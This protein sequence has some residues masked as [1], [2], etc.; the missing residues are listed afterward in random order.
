MASK[1]SYKNEINAVD[2]NYNLINYETVKEDFSWDQASRAL[3]F[4]STG[5]INAAYEAIDRHV[6]DGYGDKIA[7]HYVNGNERVD[8]TFREV[9]EKTDHYAQVL[10]NHGVKKGDRVFV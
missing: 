10:L 4:H 5:K 3:R 7:L 1:V 6:E 9:K 2:G 8:L